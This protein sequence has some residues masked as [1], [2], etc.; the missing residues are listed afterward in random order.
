MP[1]RTTSG[2]ITGFGSIIVNGVRYDISSARTMLSDVNALKLGMTVRVTG[3]IATEL[4]ALER[5]LAD[6]Q[7]RVNKRLSE[8]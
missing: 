4:R 8:L 6:K 3:A 2:A 7:R 5:E 1:P